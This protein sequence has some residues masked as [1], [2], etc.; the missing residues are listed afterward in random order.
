[1]VLGAPG[2]PRTAPVFMITKDS[3]RFD[4]GVYGAPER[5][6]LGC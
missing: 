2:R 4:L 1:M 6:S 3:L 5:L